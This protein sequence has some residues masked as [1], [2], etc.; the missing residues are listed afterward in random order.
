MK[1]KNAYSYIFLL[2]GLINPNVFALNCEPKSLPRK[3]QKFKGD[4][5]AS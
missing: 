4:L 1:N 3:Q 5:Y 2:I